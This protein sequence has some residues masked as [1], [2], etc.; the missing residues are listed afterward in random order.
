MR[1]VSG[2]LKGRIIQAP[3]GKQTRPTTDRVR[4]S[5]F[6]VLAH[7]PD[8]PDIEGVRVIDLFAGSG[9]LGFE[10]LSRG[11]SFCLF[12]EV[13]A[14]A[15]GIIRRNIEAFQLFGNT[16]IHRRSATDLGPKP[17]GV[18]E[19]FN[20]V[21]LDPPYGEGLVVPALRQLV[22]GNWIVPGT[23]AVIETPEEEE[24]EA[25]NW[26]CLE[27]RDYGETKVSFLVYKPD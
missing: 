23:L 27:T 5:V 17:N 12:V 13:A 11:A 3:E 2:S 9:A 15:R 22:L 6:N 26:V 1:I 8:I 21:F 10:A 4:E 19:P 14:G 18:G 24:P 16:R 25:E 20:L 7:N